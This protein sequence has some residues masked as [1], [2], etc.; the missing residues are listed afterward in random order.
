M[1]F[2]RYPAVYC[3]SQFKNSRVKRASQNHGLWSESIAFLRLQSFQDFSWSEL[4][5]NSYA[6]NPC[7]ILVSPWIDAS[8]EFLLSSSQNLPLFFFY[9]V[10]ELFK[11]LLY[12]FNSS[13]Y[14]DNVFQAPDYSN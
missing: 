2:H 5:R 1:S 14:D 9:S 10:Y 6:H 3:A 7:G 4:L 8:S 13:V 11:V 12:P